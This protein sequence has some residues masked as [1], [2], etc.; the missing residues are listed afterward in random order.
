MAH[1]LRRA[2]G[3]LLYAQPS[4]RTIVEGVPLLFS[5]DNNSPA[6]KCAACGLSAEAVVLYLS[7]RTRLDTFQLSLCLWTVEAIR[8][9]TD[10]GEHCHVH[11]YCL[12][13]VT[14]SK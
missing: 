14:E 6:S 12:V 2:L 7:P 8:E 11:R 13:H 10:V 1:F 9:G 3:Q 5:I 4:R